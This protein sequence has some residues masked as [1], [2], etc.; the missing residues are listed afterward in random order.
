M[1][2]IAIGT[3]D[4]EQAMESFRSR[5]GLPDDACAWQS[6]AGKLHLLYSPP[7]PLPEGWR[8]VRYEV[9]DN[10]YVFK[11]P[12]ERTETTIELE[13]LL[14]LYQLRPITTA[15][16]AKFLLLGAEP[17]TQRLLLRYAA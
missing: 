10:R 16:G 5:L 2:I 12:E 1:F 14:S 11:L 9:A 4:D 15:E 6:Q 7:V 17:Q 3:K 13:E 8:T